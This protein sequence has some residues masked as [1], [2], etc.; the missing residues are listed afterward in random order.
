MALGL[1]EGIACFNVESEPEL[2][3]LSEVA[4]RVGSRATV[5]LR[6]NPDVDAGTH[7]K[8]TT[9]K[10]ENKFGIPFRQAP[11]LYAKA[12]RLPQIEVSGVDM[13]LG[14]QITRL[15]PFEKGYALLAEL[16]TTLRAEGHDIR[17]VDIGGGLGVP[18]RAS[19]EAPPHPDEYG[20]LVKRIFGPL[21]IKVVAEPGRLLVGNAG[22]LV[23]RVIHVKRGE[24]KTFLIVDAAMNDLIRPT[25]Y[26][27]WHDI[28]PVAEPDPD[29]PSAPVDVV[30]PVCESGD[31]LAQA[32]RLP[33]FSAGDLLAFMTAGAYGAVQAGTY[34]TRPLVPEVLVKA[35]RAAI[36]RPRETYEELIGRDRLASWQE[37]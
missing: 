33:P 11:A 6:I 30:G 27:A 18:Y 26:D 14:S 36:V 22:I 37:R 25:L 1:K 8:I 13:H 23:T 21:G 24:E 2:E 31:Y 4:G 28:Q 20:A 34:N 12:A 16:V 19:N 32:R 9:G 15:E 35:S 29:A 17:H 10:A 7:A 5:S 3:L